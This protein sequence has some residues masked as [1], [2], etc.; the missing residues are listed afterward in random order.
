M[1]GAPSKPD[2]SRTVEVIGAGYSKTGTLSMQLA[3]ETLLQ[4]PVMHGGTHLLKREDAFN[5]AFYAAYQAREAG[6]HQTTLKL[7][8][9]LTAGFAGL[10]DAPIY[11]FLPELCEL[12]PEA[13][14]VLVTRDPAKWWASMGGNFEYALPWYV[15]ILT[16]PVP[17]LRYMPGI[18]SIWLQ[19]C[20]R[21]M[22]AAK[23]PGAV[24]GPDFVDIHLLM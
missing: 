16:A 19:R 10:V 13:K 4:G 2:A 21:I 6:D 8:R 23:G 18:M 11:D 9:Q 5:K 24:M 3:L 15:P 7:L 1:G 20:A 12:Y 17:G 22:E 14:V